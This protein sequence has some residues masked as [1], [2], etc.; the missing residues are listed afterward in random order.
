MLHGSID[1]DFCSTHGPGTFAV[2]AEE[3][4]IERALQITENAA[5]Q[6]GA[7]YT[8]EGIGSDAGMS[9][10]YLSDLKVAT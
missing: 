9:W 1:A 5:A 6:K 7:A 10:K 4:G 2:E 8:G 3:M